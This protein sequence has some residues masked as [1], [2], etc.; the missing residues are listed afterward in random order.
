MYVNCNR[1]LFCLNRSCNAVSSEDGTEPGVD[2]QGKVVN[3]I[4]LLRY[5]WAVGE[6]WRPVRVEY[7]GRLRKGPFESR[8]TVPMTARSHQ[9]AIAEAAAHHVGFEIYSLGEFQRDLYFRQPEALAN[10]QAAGRY[11]A[12]LGRARVALR[13]PSFLG[14]GGGVGQ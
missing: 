9:L 12:F 2:A 6:G 13:P 8:Y 4:G 14:L 10:L 11:N 5:Q 7:G 1:G 3:N